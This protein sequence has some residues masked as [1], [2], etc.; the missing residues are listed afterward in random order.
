MNSVLHVILRTFFY[1]N[2][3]EETKK[4]AL[5]SAQIVTHSHENKTTKRNL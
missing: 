1:K 2:K 5:S 3:D 4:Q